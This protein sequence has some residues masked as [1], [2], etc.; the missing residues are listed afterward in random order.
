[1]VTVH[2]HLWPDCIL[3]ITFCFCGCLESAVVPVQPLEDTKITFSDLKFG[4]KIGEGGGGVVFQGTC[5]STQVAIKEL[6]GDENKKSVCREI[7]VLR[8]LRHP[9]I[10]LY[11]GTVIES[12]RVY[13]VIELAV[14]GSLCDFFKSHPV[15]DHKQSLRWATEIAKGMRYLHENNIIHRDLKSGNILLTEDWT[16]KICDFGTAK[17][18]EHTTT[19]M[20]NMMGTWAWMSP[21]A[22]NGETVSKEFDSYS[23]SIVLWELLTHKTPFLG[24]PMSLLPGRIIQGERPVVPDNCD[25]RLTSLMQQCW[26]D[27]RKRRPNFERI[28]SILTQVSDHP[29]PPSCMHT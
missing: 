24:T 8:K 23:Y 22:L 20:T 27:N 25:P 12:H 5:K 10:I 17:Q 9:N 29:P 26:D 7:N 4:E 3:F 14:K 1:M 21:E 6:Y 28:V 2:G 18:V 16:A 11:Y 13:V 15:P 19:Q